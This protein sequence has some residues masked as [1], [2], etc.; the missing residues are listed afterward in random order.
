MA[1]LIRRYRFRAAFRNN[2]PTARATF[3]PQVYQPVGGFNHI[4]IVLDDDDAIASFGQ[5]LQYVQ[6]LVDAGEMQAGGGFVE[7]I[8]RAAGVSLGEFPARA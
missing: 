6:Q 1:G 2:L 8:K 7:D 5:A 4:Q 3:R